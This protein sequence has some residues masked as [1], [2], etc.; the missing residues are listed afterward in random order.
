MTE[1]IFFAREKYP[2]DNSQSFSQPPQY[3]NEPI[4]LLH[5]SAEKARTGS[6]GYTA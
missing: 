5:T 1:L 4:H 2:A 6:G 3:A